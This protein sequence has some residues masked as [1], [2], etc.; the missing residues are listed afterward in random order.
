MLVSHD[1]LAGLIQSTGLCD[2]GLFDDFSINIRLDSQIIRMKDRSLRH[3]QIIYG[4]PYNSGE[5]FEALTRVQRDLPLKPG[6][7]VL[8]CSADDYRMPNGYLGLVQTKGSLA[9]LFISATCNDAQVEPGYEGRITLEL[10]NL[11]NSDV[12]IPVHSVVAQ[13]FILRCST[14][15]AAPYSG[16]YQGATGPTLARFPE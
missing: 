10:M 14:E 7:R 6:D 2:P 4:R 1:N 11:G 3:R 8:A 16:R 5:H 13:L 12:I 15:T 9:R